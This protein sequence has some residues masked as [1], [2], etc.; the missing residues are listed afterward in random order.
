M[1]DLYNNTIDI[2]YMNRIVHISQ[3][4]P[5]K[6]TELWDSVS[7]NQFISKKELLTTVLESGILSKDLSVTII[8]SWFGSIL[9]PV[10][11][12]LVKDIICFDVDEEAGHIATQLHKYDNVIFSKQDLSKQRV[13]TLQDAN[14]LLVINTSCEHMDDMIDIMH[15]QH[16]NPKYKQNPRNIWI[17]CQSNN[18]LDI[19]GHINCVSSMKEFKLQMPMEAKILKEMEIG[20]ER[21]IR[22]FIFGMIPH[23]KETNE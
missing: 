1:I 13:K 12:P 3:R 20:E 17:A 8:G 22:Y 2:D 5:E 7:P 6:A 10:L 23:R 16:L 11:A 4:F 21:G 14:D 19:E 15:L 18:M 9:V